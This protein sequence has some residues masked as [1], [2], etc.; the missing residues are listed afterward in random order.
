MEMMLRIER[1]SYGPDAIAHAE[2]GRVVFVAGAV[3]GDVVCAQATEERKGYIKANVA[4]VVEPSPNRVIPKDPALLGS[5]EPWSI[6]SYEAQLAAKR[7]NVIDALSR[8]GK[9]PKAEAES[10]VQDIISSKHEWGYRNKLEMAAFADAQGRF[11]LGFTEQGT[12]DPISVKEC[13]LGVRTIAKAPGKLTGAIRYM[14]GSQDLGIYRVGVRSSLRTK[15]LEVA[16]WTPPSSFPRDFAQK[17]LKEAV[18]AT[19]VVRVLAKPGSKRQVKRV[20]VIAGSGV[21]TEELAGF[22]FAVSAPAF[23]QVNTRQAEV[24]IQFVMDA[25]QPAEGMRVVDL[26]SGVGTF[27]IPLAAYG[28]DVTAVE[29]S[30]PAV[31]DLR[32]N[33]E[34]NGVW[35]DA[36]CDDAKRA[37]G[38]LEGADAIV[39]DPPRAGLDAEVLTAICESHPKRVVYVS[40]DPQTL[41]RDVARF[42]QQGYALLSAA[43]VDMF[44]QTYHVECVSVFEAL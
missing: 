38:E 28:A 7:T 5:V 44:P 43:P 23:F 16:L 18:G 35:V 24:L 1:M 11:T 13:S 29:L 31:R 41:A 30:G 42:S 4:E 9:L 3:P 27:S 20:E 33:A 39:V 14:Q 19:S 34:A 2:D 36:I 12:D 17:M 21:W 15:S 6:L 26:F 10:L 22:Q 37:L 25:I 40:C 32:R 8:T